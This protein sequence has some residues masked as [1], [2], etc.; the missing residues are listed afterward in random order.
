MGDTIK[1]GNLDISSFKVGRDDCSIYLGDVKLYPQTNLPYDAEIE[2]LESTGT[3]WINT[4][5]FANL[6]TIVELEGAMTT[7]FND[8]VFIGGDEGGS[9]L[10][11]FVIESY[12]HLGFLLCLDGRA[13]CFVSRFSD[14]NYHH[15]KA[16]KNYLII[17]DSQFSTYEQ[18]VPQSFTSKQPLYMFGWNRS[19]S[20]GFYGKVRIS[21]LKI[22]SDT[23]LIRDYIPVR[24]DGVGYMYDKVSG[25][26]FGNVGTG[27]FVLGNDVI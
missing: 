21:Y 1:I 9:T 17:D 14:T 20:V 6:N 3:Q 5:V 11:S 19:G 7:V 22:F 25:Q 26:L 10:N 2:Y 4:N 13:P 15:I 27:D 24:K 12:K 18:G 8:N 16:C 23:T